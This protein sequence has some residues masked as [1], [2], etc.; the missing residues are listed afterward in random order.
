MSRISYDT[1]KCGK[2]KEV[3]SKLCK[4]CRAEIARTSSE[5]YQNQILRMMAS[6]KNTKLVAEALG[7]SQNGISYH[8]AN[9]KRRFGANDLFELGMKAAKAGII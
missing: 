6:N 4:A 2:Q 5:E 8:I 7:I 3:R 9:M 1:C